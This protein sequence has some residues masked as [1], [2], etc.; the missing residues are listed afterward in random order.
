MKLTLKKIVSLISTSPNCQG[1][2]HPLGSVSQCVDPPPDSGQLCI[3][4]DLSQVKLS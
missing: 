4:Q 1:K 2:S 3:E